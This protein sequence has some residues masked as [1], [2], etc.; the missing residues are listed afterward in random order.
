MTKNSRKTLAEAKKIAKLELQLRKS[1]NHLARTLNRRGVRALSRDG[2]SRREL[3][4]IHKSLLHHIGRH[5]LILG[6][7]AIIGG[8][9]LWHGLWNLVDIT[10]L[11]TNYVLSIS[12][13]LFLLWLFNKYSDV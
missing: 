12:I 6:L 8:V 2:L 10:P 3:G 7:I 9:L 4:L 5:K 1:E 13:G 11:A